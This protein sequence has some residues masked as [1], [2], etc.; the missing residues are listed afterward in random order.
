[1][2][3]L[4]SVARRSIERIPFKERPT[5]MRCQQTRFLSIALVLP[6]IGIAGCIDVDPSGAVDPATGEIMEAVTTAEGF[7]SGTKTAYAAGS[8]MLGSGV[9]NLSD[10][11]I[12]TL[13]TDV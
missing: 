8:V 12:G 1:M 6:M 11:L 4:T 13:S 10:A 3:M 7:E 9:W 5:E 2:D